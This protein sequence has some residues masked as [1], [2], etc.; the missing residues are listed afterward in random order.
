MSVLLLDKA[1]FP[2][3]KPCGGGVTARARDLLPFDI[4][5][6]VEQTIDRVRFDFRQTARIT[7]HSDRPLVYLTQRRRLDAFLVEQALEKGVTLRERAR[8]R[9][10]HQDSDLVSVR[11]SDETF[12]GRAVVAA[13]GCAGQ[14]ARLAGVETVCRNQIA[15]EGN[16]YLGKDELSEWQGTIGLHAAWWKGG[17]GW[18]FPKSDHLNIG[19]AGWKL[20]HATL[21]GSLARLAQFYG[22]APEAI[23]DIKGSPIPWRAASSPL[24]QGRLLLVGDAAGL[25]DPISD[26]GIHAAFWSGSTAA[27]H[28][29]KV[30][31]GE[32]RDLHGYRRE[33][34]QGLGSDIE[35]SQRLHDFV[36]FLPKLVVSLERHGKFFTPDAF[37]MVLGDQAF[38]QLRKKYKRFMPIVEF[39]SHF[40]RR[41]E[42][43]RLHQRSGRSF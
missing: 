43:H 8:V 15:L 41:T 28:L 18:I 25:V 2:R 40:V 35:V 1:E 27:R 29:A 10:V 21:R 20:G 9:E 22:Y 14:T 31:S 23:E 33:I 42:A 38:H 3:D 19:V 11:T 30:V 32:A 34:E 4:S 7:R 13:D 36:H 16:L 39:V 17:Y 6:V 26:E 12:R 5:P 24:E 37:D